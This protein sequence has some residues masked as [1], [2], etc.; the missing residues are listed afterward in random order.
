MPSG[1][2][3]AAA[4]GVATL[5][6]VDALASAGYTSAEAARS[7]SVHTALQAGDQSAG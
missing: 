6:L 5:P 3:L 1:V 7:G 4:L 2:A